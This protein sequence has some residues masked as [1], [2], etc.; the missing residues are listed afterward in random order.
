MDRFFQGFP[1]LELFDIQNWVIGWEKAVSPSP[2]IMW[3]P[4]FNSVFILEINCLGWAASHKLDNAF[5]VDIDADKN[6][7][8]RDDNKIRVAIKLPRKVRL[9]PV[10]TYMKVKICFDNG[11]MEGTKFLNHQSRES[12]LKILINLR[13][14]PFVTLWEMSVICLVES[15]KLGIEVI[16]SNYIQKEDGSDPFIK[17]LRPGA[18]RPQSPLGDTP[19][20]SN[21]KCFKKH[22]K[23]THPAS[24]SNTPTHCA[25]GRSKRPTSYLQWHSPWLQWLYPSTATSHPYLHA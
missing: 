3:G 19:P 5:M 8:P 10:W 11:V 6:R 12:S 17:P 18:K 23:S 7:K 16:Q 13:R 9:E 15:L 1:E 22:P 14:S 24:G 20:P 2:P 25:T 4:T 21:Q